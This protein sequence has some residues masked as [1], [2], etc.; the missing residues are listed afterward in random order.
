[1]N[2]RVKGGDATP[3]S[4]PDVQR[5]HVALPELD[6]RIQPPSQLHHRR[7]QIHPENSYS[8]L[9]EVAGHMPRSTAEVAGGAR[10]LNPCR[11]SVE[12]LAVERFMLQ[13][14][15][16]APGIFLSDTIVAALNLADRLVEA[17]VKD[18]EIP[19]GHSPVS[20]TST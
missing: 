11:E 8:S 4:L 9:V 19:M 10:S 15:E 1:M 13:L 3:C 12:K 6:A 2:D 16:D 7:R 14:P 20:P 18:P 5:E 17:L